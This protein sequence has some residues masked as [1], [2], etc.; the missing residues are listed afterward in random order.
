MK[1]QNN[2]FGGSSSVHYTADQHPGD[3]RQLLKH[4]TT[5]LVYYSHLHKSWKQDMPQGP[6]TQ[7]HR[8]QS[9]TFPTESRRLPSCKDAARKG[10]W[11][12]VK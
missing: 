4:Q 11:S 3:Y 10:S 1:Q 8:L 2:V 7:T 5:Q 9:V 12:E 6:H